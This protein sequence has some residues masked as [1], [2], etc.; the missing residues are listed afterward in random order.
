MTISVAQVMK[1]QIV[2]FRHFI[3]LET[4]N[5]AKDVLLAKDE[6]YML[7]LSALYMVT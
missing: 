4:H 3:H 5:G 6:F 7:V 1:F 2:K